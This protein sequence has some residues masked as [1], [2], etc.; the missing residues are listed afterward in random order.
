MVGEGGWNGTEKSPKVNSL[1]YNDK[2]SISTEDRTRG[3]GLNFTAGG[4]AVRPQEELPG[5]EGSSEVIPSLSLPP[6]RTAPPPASGTH[7]H[8]DLPKLALQGRRPPSFAPTP[9]PRGRIPSSG[10]FLRFNLD[11]L[12][13]G[14][15]PVAYVSRGWVSLGPPLS[16]EF[17]HW[18]AGS[19][20]LAGSS[21]AFLRHPSL[22]ALPPGL[23][24]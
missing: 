14:P 5:L 6:G 16:R 12:C 22:A 8:R 20:V 9:E 17:A 11:P 1:E 15:Q 4:M 2:F 3:N 23:G 21:Q 24:R 7:T 13:C 18:L 19:L 10:T